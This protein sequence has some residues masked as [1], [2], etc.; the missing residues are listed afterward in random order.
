MSRPNIAE[1]T[2]EVSKQAAIIADLR[3][4]LVAAKIEAA[5]AKEEVRKLHLFLDAD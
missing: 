3:E 5:L 2:R 4:R 1:L